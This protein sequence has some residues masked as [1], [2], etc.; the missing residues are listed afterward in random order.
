MNAEDLIARVYPFFDHPD[1]HYAAKVIRASPFYVPQLHQKPKQAVQYG[2]DD[3]EVTEPPDEP[4]DRKASEFDGMPFIDVRFSKVPRSSHGLL[5]GCTKKCDVVLPNIKGPSNY[6][7]CLTFDD[8]NRFIV[9]DLDSSLGTEVTYDN[10]G[11][12]T[13][14]KFN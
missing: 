8:Q 11:K 4:A 5:F 2:R 1:L 14:R 6:H 10:K 13:R 3:R 12:G 9:K 7:F